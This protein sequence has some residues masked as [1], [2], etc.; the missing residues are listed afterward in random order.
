MRRLFTFLLLALTILPASAMAD[1]GDV[2][3]DT[4]I[5]LLRAGLSDEAIIAVVD[6]PRTDFDVEP[7]ALIRL[8]EVGLS[9][10]VIV[11]IIAAEKR[12]RPA[13]TP[14]VA[15]P[16]VAVELPVAG[17]ELMFWDSI[18]HSTSVADYE[19]Y[20]L[21]YP[22]GHF[23]TLAVARLETMREQAAAT[24]AVPS[25]VS[26]TTWPD[27]PMPKT[28]VEAPAQVV[29]AEPLTEGQLMRDGGLM[30]A[31][32]GFAEEKYR[33]EID[34]FTRMRVV[35]QS[36]NRVVIETSYLW[37]NDDTRNRAGRGMVTLHR[38]ESSYMVVGFESYHP[39]SLQLLRFDH[40]ASG[41]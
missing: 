34:K 24:A 6:R 10:A 15:V 26:S 41:L 23:T 38:N 14:S 2:S 32:S 33:F 18:K 7:E 1:I 21:Q 4:V 17:F 35:A 36:N 22:Y 31:I 3:N 12:A 16:S 39:T 19:A 5:A 20:L 11:A 30:A 13:E 29:P 25:G 27:A 37:G 28:R 8:R 40:G 9:N